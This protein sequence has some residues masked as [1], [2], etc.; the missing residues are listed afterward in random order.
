MSQESVEVVRR[1]IAYE[2]YGVGDRRR[3]GGDL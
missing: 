2:Y 1:A 3:S